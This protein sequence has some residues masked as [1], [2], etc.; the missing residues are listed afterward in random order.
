[1]PRTPFIWWLRA[2]SITSEA[3]PFSCRRVEPVRL[4][5]CIVNGGISNVMLPMAWF[6]ALCEKGFDK[7]LLPGITHADPPANTSTPERAWL[8]VLTEKPCAVGLSWNSQPG[9]S[10]LHLPNPHL[11]I[12]PTATRPCAQA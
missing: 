11:S 5:S 4:R 9:S 7:L 8:L 12:V 10:T 3:K 6:I 1:M 2:F